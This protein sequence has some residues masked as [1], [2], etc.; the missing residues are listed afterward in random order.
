MDLGN[1]LLVE[2]NNCRWSVIDDHRTSDWLVDH[3][4]ITLCLS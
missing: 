2:L 4:V 1:D 3:E